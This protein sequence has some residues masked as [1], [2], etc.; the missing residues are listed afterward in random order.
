[1]SLILPVL[2]SHLSPFLPEFLRFLRLVAVVDAVTI[3][4]LLDWEGPLW[5]ELILAGNMLWWLLVT[6][7]LA[8][9]FLLSLESLG[10][11]VT[12]PGACR[13]ALKGAAATWVSKFQG[14][15]TIARLLLL[16]PELRFDEA[17]VR[18][19]LDTTLFSPRPVFLS[20]FKCVFD[21]LLWS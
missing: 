7:G 15:S 21:G 5:V 11:G 3:E 6:D 18:F 14:F 13:C 16:L 10:C 17:F 20:T 1:M 4:A 19:L 8:L 2:S 12:L 9:P